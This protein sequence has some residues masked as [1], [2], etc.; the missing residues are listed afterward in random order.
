MT[1]SVKI[2]SQVSGM[3][4]IVVSF[5]EVGTEKEDQKRPGKGKISIFNMLSLR[6]L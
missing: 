4:K 1:G 6:C 2:D 3:Q 5:N